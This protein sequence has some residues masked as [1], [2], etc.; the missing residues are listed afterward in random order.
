MASRTP[1]SSSEQGDNWIRQ[2]AEANRRLEN[3]ARDVSARTTRRRAEFARA[4]TE[5]IHRLRDLFETAATT[6]NQA[7]PSTPVS[8]TPLTGGSFTV[9]RG[10][11]RLT[12]LKTADWNVAFSFS[13]PPKMDLFALL[14]LVED[15]RIAWRLYRKSDE[16]DKLEAVPL[17]GA[18]VGELVSR[19]LFARLIQPS[20]FIGTA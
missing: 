8:V 5:V 11:R 20:A 10:G 2:L 15:E 18:D 17:E 9:A 12:V 16:M 7:S 1:R 3:D 19:Q 13:N 14:S 4:A 6:F